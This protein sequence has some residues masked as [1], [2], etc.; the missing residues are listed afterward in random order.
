[1]SERPYRVGLVGFQGNDSLLLSCMLSIHSSKWSRS[2]EVSTN[3]SPQVIFCDVSGSEGLTKW[4][5]AQGNAQ[6]ILVAYTPTPMLGVPWQLGKPVK[7]QEL[8]SLVQNLEL[9]LQ[10][11][12]PHSVKVSAPSPAAVN[13]PSSLFPENR[14]T[15]LRSRF[16]ALAEL[17]PSEATGTQEMKLI[18]GGSTGAGK[19][20]A[21]RTISDA[22][23]VQTEARPSDLVKRMKSETTVALDYGTFTLPNG[24]K[25]LLYGTP[26]QVRFE[27]MSEILCRGGLGLVLLINNSGDNPMH[28]LTYYLRLHGDFIRKTGAVLGVTHMDR[29]KAPTLEDY[30]SYLMREKWEI[31][32]CSVDVRDREQIVALLETLIAQ[33]ESRPSRRA[34]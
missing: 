12:S 6:P 28:E 18:F 14:D 20:T 8:I 21:L 7:T 16:A 25:L 19:S 11:N 33:L 31:P 24:K 10:Q 29:K 23:P 1:M 34:A 13:A 2:W 4:Q 9:A 32:A 22:A 26:G 17:R 30:E 5:D 27:F 3:G 15:A